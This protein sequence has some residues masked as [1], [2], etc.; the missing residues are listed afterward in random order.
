MKSLSR[1]AATNAL[2]RTMLGELLRRED[3]ESLAR[4][5]SVE[6][7]WIALRKTAYERWLPE[8]A[9]TEVLGIEKVITE[10]TAS[11]FRRSLANLRGKT[12]EV[13]RLLLARWE[14]DNLEFALR[15]WHAKDVSLAKFL[16]E[17]QI[18]NAIPIYDVVEAESIEKIAL[19]LRHTP[20]FEALASS[21]DTYNRRKA[22]F[23]VEIELEKHYYRRLLDA[24][25][26]LGGIDA[27]R[28]LK[29]MGAEIDIINVTLLARLMEYHQVKPEDLRSCVI[30]GP[31][32][33]SRLL[34]SSEFSAAEIEDVKS[35]I[36]GQYA[37]EISQQKTKLDSVSMLEHMVREAAVGIA[38]TML[39]GYPFSITCVFAFYLLKRNELENLRTVFGGMAIGASEDEILKQLFG[40]G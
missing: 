6:S 26:A 20:Y 12:L 40:I 31:S 11:R 30:E 18:V 16:I 23:F 22:I 10:V 13:G 4:A 24:A 5:E 29:I 27:K 33:I 9:P 3:Y 1:Y 35:R 38:R 32:E 21:I 25:V 15:L 8:E 2:T 34:S 7:A 19:E 28:A 36:L 14:L 17:S 37:G 39:M